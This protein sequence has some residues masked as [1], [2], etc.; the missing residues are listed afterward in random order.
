MIKT[1]E[2]IPCRI[3]AIKFTGA[4]AIEVEIFVGRALKKEVFSSSAYEVGKG[5]LIV[6]LFIDTLEGEMKATSGDYI[7]K[8]LKGEFY[9]CKPEVF[10]MKYKEVDE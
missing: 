8:G 4:N 2:T 10:E 1:Y 6:S 3:E 9:P 5:P 7:I